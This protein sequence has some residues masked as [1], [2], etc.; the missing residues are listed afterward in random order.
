MA[1]AANPASGCSPVLDHS[2][3]VH[4]Q[5]ASL[6]N[7]QEHRLWRDDRESRTRWVGASGRAQQQAQR[8]ADTCCCMPPCCR[9]AAQRSA[10]QR[11]SKL[12]AKLTRLSAKAASALASSTDG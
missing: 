12:E 5:R 6:A 9:G 1:P 8:P 3:N 7:Q 4:G 10:M 2:R 11:Q